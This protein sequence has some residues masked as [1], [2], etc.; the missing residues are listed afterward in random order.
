MGSE[1]DLGN[2]CQARI[3]EFVPGTNFPNPTLTPIPFGG[4]RPVRFPQLRTLVS[5]LG[6]AMG[7]AKLSAQIPQTEYA[8]RRAAL[9][10]K[11]Q[12]GVL[13]AIGGKEP[14][15]DYL[16]FFQNEPFTSLTGYNEPNAALVMGKPGGETS[17]MLFVGERNPAAEVWTGKRLGPEGA[18]KLTGIDARPV[19][20]LRPVLDSL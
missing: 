8:Q 3:R 18:T 11:M 12:D 19:E 9:A 17:A 6:L 16:S 7:A 10:A 5:G 13:L 1:S 20:Q 4:G 14:A 2:W 15:Q